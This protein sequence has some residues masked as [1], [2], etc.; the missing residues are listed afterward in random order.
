MNK[1]LELFL[2][3]SWWKLSL[4][5]SLDVSKVKGNEPWTLLP[6]RKKGLKSGLVIKSYTFVSCFS[7]YY[8][9]HS[10]GGWLPFSYL[11]WLSLN[12]KIPENVQ[13]IL[14]LKII[15][16]CMNNLL[17][18]WVICNFSLKT[19]RSNFLHFYYKCFFFRTAIQTI[20]N[21]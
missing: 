19:M 7:W 8:F 18:F 5:R 6:I 2:I 20:L 15:K 3:F 11:L 4:S 10:S 13:Y 12:H 17:V 14:I 1:N 21:I 16:N 9:F